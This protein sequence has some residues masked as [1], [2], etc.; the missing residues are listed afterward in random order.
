MQITANIADCGLARIEIQGGR[1][2]TVQLCGPFDPTMPLV[3]PGFVDIQLNG[4]GGVN[5]SHSDLTVEEAIRIL[6]FVWETGVTSFCPTLITNKVEV[7][8]RNF[9]VLEDARNQNRLFAQTVPCYHLEGPYLSPGGARGAHDPKL[10]RY[11][12]WDEFMRL[13]DAAGGNIA[14]ITLAPE[15]PGALEFISRA[16][17]S[18]TTVAIGHTDANP[19][20]IHRAVQAGA[21][22]ATHFGNGCA[23]LIH[24]HNNP[25]WAQLVRPEL[26]ASIICDGFHIPPELAKVVF[27]MKGVGRCILVTDAIHV[28]GL[29]PGQYDLVGQKIELLPGGNVLLLERSS[30]A[31]SSL[32]MNRAVI[33]FTK[34]AEANLSEALEAATATPGRLLRRDGICTA[35]DRGQW[36]NLIFFK[37]ESDSLRV[38]IAMLRGETVYTRPKSEMINVEGTHGCR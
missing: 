13:Q 24:R 4:F 36:A 9:R 34:L 10:M 23:E 18:G 31:G 7:L 6:P 29:P 1:I 14:I 32:G 8:C 25:L 17:A 20:Q 11:P 35:L 5:F 12:N 22:L 38:E 2:R 33:G 37:V 21:T 3:S 28:A 19:E 16:R 27:R 15:L 30:M 26:S